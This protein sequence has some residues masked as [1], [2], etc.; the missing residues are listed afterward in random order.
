MNVLNDKQLDIALGNSRKTKRWKNKP[1]QWSELL[2]RLA[3]TTRTPET[4]AEYKAMSR[5]R[6]SEV[7]DVGGFVGGY[8]N[9]GSRSDIRFRS[10]VCLDADYADGELWDDW[11]LLYGNAAAVYSTHK[12]TPAKPRLRV[13]IPLARN[14]SPDEYQAVGR[15]VAAVLGIDMSTWTDGL[16]GNGR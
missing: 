5:D 15:R 6:Q 8:C 2:D 4:L 11:C 7:K 9:N 1:M 10:I 14:V 12:H 3:V 16:N 13:V